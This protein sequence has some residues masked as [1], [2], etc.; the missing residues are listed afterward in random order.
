ME[1]FLKSVAKCYYE[2]EKEYLCDYSFVFPNRR[3]SLFFLNHLRDL[4]GK[5]AFIAPNI[6]TISDFVE[7][8]SGAES[9]SSIETLLL[10]YN[11]Y[12]RTKSDNSI[13]EKTFEQFMHIGDTIV[14]DFSDIDKFYSD[15]RLVL[16]NLK[17]VQE[18][19]SNY[20]S[21]ELIDELSKYFNIPDTLNFNTEKFWKHTDSNVKKQFN[22]L[23][24]SLYDFYVELNKE[25]DSQNKGYSGAIYRKAYDNIKDSSATDF[26]YK[27]YVFV[28][29]NALSATE[30]LIFKR[31]QILGIGDYYWD[32]V[33]EIFPDA[34]LFISK[35]IKQFTSK[36][37]IG[38]H[39][40]DF[41]S[42]KVL[43]IPSNIGQIKEIVD[44]VNN[45]IDTS[46]PIK[47][48]I[49]LPNESIYTPMMA[50][51]SA[52]LD[53]DYNITFGIPLK[54]T[55][56]AQLIS[57]V[58]EM[59]RKSKKVKSEFKFRKDNVLKVLSQVLIQKINPEA[60]RIL[61]EKIQESN[62]SLVDNCIFND[63]DETLKSIFV[64]IENLKDRKQTIGYIHNLLE[65]V[66]NSETEEKQTYSKVFIQ[67]YTEALE[68][69]EAT[70][71]MY[72]IE[73]NLNS[74]LFLIDRLV[75][76]LTVALKGEPLKGLQIMGF[77][78]SRCLDFD[79]I[80]IASANEHILPR[81]QSLKSFI[82][83]YIKRAAGIATSEFQES[84]YSYYFFRL[85]SRAK[86][87]YIC[88]DSRKQKGLGAGEQSRYIYQLK[89]LY[90]THDIRFLELS[91][92]M[93][94]MSNGD[95]EIT[96]DQR[97]L[98]KINLFFDKGDN[99]HYLSASA[100]KDYLGC[101]LCFYLK[102]VERLRYEDS[103]DS[104]INSATFGTIV[105]D[106]LSKIYSSTIGNT[107][108]FDVINSLYD[109]VDKL[110]E[111]SITDNYLNQSS[112]ANDS[113]TQILFAIIKRYVTAVLDFDKIKRS[114]FSIMELEQK[115]KRSIQIDNDLSINLSFTIDRVDKGM[116][117]VYNIIDYK[118]GGDKIS[119][120]DIETAFNDKHDNHAAFQVML[121]C[122]A[123]SQ[124]NADAKNTQPYIYR[125]RDL[126]YSDELK[127]ALKCFDENSKNEFRLKLV[128]K[129][130]EIR[131][132]DIPFRQTEDTDNCK[133]CGF[134]EF[135]KK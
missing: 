61:T 70:L 8:L 29:F 109:H 49:V 125:L 15:A 62:S 85:I 89:Y 121:Y 87:V 57:M 134:K 92:Q 108:S 2:N 94:G 53:I 81:K 35:N 28:G 126:N 115:Y 98:E 129:L 30:Y 60:T 102:H 7:E 41:P 58:A 6:T 26:E 37:D 96:K 99:A 100:L 40:N 42:I 105:H 27:R 22:S 132:K 127:P 45:D 75:S 78:E 44:L 111:E 66:N 118:T 54:N 73:T 130:N 91:Y 59:H 25:L 124:I 10:L 36:Y 13:P 95:I 12:S 17:E 103:D 38:Q 123:Y 39:R 24:D 32:Y 65:I 16:S 88:Y 18:I 107:C 64:T 20:L 82:P 4:Y 9:A 19:K 110:I 86:N 1:P 48:A 135:C 3:S 83:S 90:K 68:E 93:S 117:N 34:S 14:N 43:A 55:A 50:S 23:W 5:E 31:F 131:N 101:P 52:L 133:F 11:I 97:I 84:L 46:D 72:G 104:F 80:I 21:Q 119:V 114:D 120:K 113:D 74:Y 47:T 112:K 69:I 116:D 79:N 76:R 63:C 128:E 67:S 71:D 77:L 106:V 33:S 122:L 51:A 56:V